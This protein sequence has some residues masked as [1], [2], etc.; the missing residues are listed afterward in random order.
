MSM[1]NFKGINIMDINK[2]TAERIKALRKEKNL[3]AEKLAWKSELSKSC[4]TYAEKAQRDIKLTTIQSLCNGFNI[5]IA[6]F[7]S[8]F[9]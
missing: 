4:V 7:F 6:E 1:Y 2:L 9:K 8:T 3:T 5:S